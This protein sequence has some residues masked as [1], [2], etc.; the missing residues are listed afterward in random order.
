[1]I[2]YFF[3]TQHKGHFCLRV[4]HD[5]NIILALLNMCNRASYIYKDHRNIHGCFLP[6]A[7]DPSQIQPNLFSPNWKKKQQPWKTS[8]LTCL[9]QPSHADSDRKPF[10]VFD[11]CLAHSIPVFLHIYNYT[12]NVSLHLCVCVKG[13]SNLLAVSLSCLDKA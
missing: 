2:K 6:S 8:H 9:V 12:I 4:W 13:Y 10:C 5:R 7:A 11:A 1:M 3:F